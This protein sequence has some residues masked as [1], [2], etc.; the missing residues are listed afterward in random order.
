MSELLYRIAITK[1]PKVG[2]VTAKNLIGYC[3]SAEA[4]FKARKKELVKIPGVGESVADCILHQDVLAWAEGERQFLEKYEIQALFHT[5]KAYPQRLK[6]LHDAPLMLYYKGTAELNVERTIAIVGTR[7]PSSH[8]K[9]ICEELVEGLKKYNPL[10]VSGLAYGID[11]A[12]HR[13]CVELGMANIGVLGNGL[14]S[15]YPKDHRQVAMKMCE[16]GGLITEFPSDT[17]PERENFPM[18]NRIIAGMSDA[19][20]VVESGK[21]GGSIIT[22]E[23]ANAYNRDVFAVPGRPSDK[24]AAG[25]NHLIRTNK[26]ALIE[27]AEDVAYLMRWDEGGVVKPGVQCQLFVDLEEGERVVYEILKQSDETVIDWIITQTGLPPGEISSLLLML[28]FKGMVRSLP[29]KRY[30]VV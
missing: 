25:C 17:Q 5:D 11:V 19:V 13:K 8:G 21:R 28:E 18:R 1:I 29:G 12:A 14:R 3:G 16:N 22:T 27:T 4:V 20:I 10:I 26:A 30:M 7:G 6:H 23:L 2:A 9:A 15:V 24:H